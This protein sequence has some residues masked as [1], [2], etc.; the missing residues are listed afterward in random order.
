MHLLGKA[1]TAVPITRFTLLLCAQKASKQWQISM[2]SVQSVLI[3]SS[4]TDARAWT[5]CLDARMADTLSDLKKKKLSGHMR[6]LSHQTWRS[7]MLNISLSLSSHVVV[8]WWNEDFQ[9]RW[10]SKTLSVKLYRSRT[11]GG[12]GLV[13]HCQSNCYSCPSRADAWCSTA[14]DSFS[15]GSQDRKSLVT[16]P[17][18]LVF[19]QQKDLGLQEIS[20]QITAA[21]WTHSV[22]DC[23]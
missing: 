23:V 18:E 7:I 20:S 9:G 21:A 13:V 19:S 6:L 5:T 14:A 10:W 1:P 17:V 11:N 16:W 12:H 22:A 3:W 15:H 8:L 4:K 2:K